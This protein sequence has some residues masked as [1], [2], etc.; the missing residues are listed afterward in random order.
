MNGGSDQTYSGDLSARQ[1]WDLL[2]ETPDATL[3]D[4]RTRAE[5]SYVGTVDLSVLGKDAVLL[6]WQSFPDRQVN[7]EFVDTLLAELSRRGVGADEP[8]LFLCRSGVRSAAA[9]RAVTAAGRDRCYNIAGGFEG[10]LDA[11]RH[12]GRLRGWKAENLP[13]VQ[14]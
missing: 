11:D 1:A 3:I 14:S 7:P 4:V 5:W 12:R 9:A 8:L 6:E 13:W 2:N 10:G